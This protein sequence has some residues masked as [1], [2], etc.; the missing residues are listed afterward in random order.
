MLD[1]LIRWST[2]YMAVG[3]MIAGFLGILFPAAMK[4]YAR[5]IPTLLGIIMFGMGMSLKAEDFRNVFRDPR[6]VAVGAILQFTIM[7]LLA[8]VL[9]TL[10]ALPPEIAIGVVLVGCC[11][12][13]TASN[14]ISFIAHADVALSVSMT[15]VNTILAPFITPL[16]IYLIAGT[17]I[18]ISLSSMMLSIVKMVLLP[19]FWALRATI[20]F[21]AL[22]P[23]FPASCPCSLPLS[24]W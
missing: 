1:K 22:Y 5:F 21:P 24:L 17:W 12:G 9:V 19:S 2:R 18:E 16:L 4:P 14:V 3:V 10:L 15:M 8:Y 7:P 11:P 20:S 6:S 23:V 13:G